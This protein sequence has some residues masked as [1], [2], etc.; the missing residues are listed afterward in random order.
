[1]QNLAMRSLSLL[2]V[3]CGANA[4]DGSSTRTA[5]LSLRGGGASL[6][7]VVLA[8]TGG[9][10]SLSGIAALVECVLHP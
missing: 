7:Q 1:M 3:A 5:L 8:S 9:A 2:L 6:P 4:K 10:L